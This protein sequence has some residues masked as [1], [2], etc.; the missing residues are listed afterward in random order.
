[1]H[2][3][4]QKQSVR[5]KKNDTL[6]SLSKLLKPLDILNI[7]ALTMEKFANP[8]GRKWKTYAVLWPSH[9]VVWAVFLRVFLA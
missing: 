6:S 8:K 4:Q 2:F 9:V 3:E 1:M 5:K 7:K